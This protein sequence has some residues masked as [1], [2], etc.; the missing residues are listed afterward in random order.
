MGDYFN[1]VVRNRG[2]SEQRAIN[3]SQ[4]EEARVRFLLNRLKLSQFKRRLLDAWE[5]QHSEKRLRLAAFNHVFPTFPFLLCSHRLRGV[6]LPGRGDKVT[7]DSYQVHRDPASVEASRF[8]KFSR[9]PFV[10]A[11]QQMLEDLGE[12]AGERSVAM[13]FPRKGLL[14][15]LV[16]HNDATEQYW[17]HGL[18]WVYKP[19]DSDD[20]LYVQPFSALIDEIYANGRGWRPDTVV[21]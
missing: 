8:K 2:A 7:P 20:R 15:G 10:I 4:F 9:V 3:E 13:V 6:P 18:S 12:E 5:R 1:D 16:I 11:Y 21:D 17:T 19:P 14:H